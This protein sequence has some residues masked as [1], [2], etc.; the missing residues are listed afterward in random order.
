[1]GYNN[2]GYLEM[3]LLHIVFH[4]IPLAVKQCIHTRSGEQ[5]MKTLL[6]L[7]SILLSAQSFSEDRLLLIPD[8]GEPSEGIIVDEAYYASEKAE[9]TSEDMALL[10]GGDFS[11]EEFARNHLSIEGQVTATIMVMGARGNVGVRMLWD[12]LEV[13]VD[14]GFI[15]I[16]AGTN[17]AFVPE[18]GAYLKLRLNPT[19]ARTVYFKGR[20]YKAWGLSDDIESTQEFG[21]GMESRSGMFIELS[22]RKFE[23]SDG[24]IYFPF[25]SVGGRFGGP[26]PIQQRG[27]YLFDDEE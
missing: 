23:D 18:V 13:G 17:G 7:F 6:I 2:Y 19:A 14:G 26:R 8:G 1:M 9:E 25:L 21:V 4:Q 24:D 11:F 16:A 12:H 20:V 5:K 27:S 15:F 22:V 10:D 3:Y